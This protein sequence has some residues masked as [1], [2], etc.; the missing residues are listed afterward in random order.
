MRQS[1][2]PQWLIPKCWFF[3]KAS[4]WLAA[5]EYPCIAEIVLFPVYLTWVD[6]QNTNSRV[7]NTIGLETDQKLQTQQ[8]TDPASSRFSIAHTPLH[9]V[10]TPYHFQN[11]SI[12]LKMLL[13]FLW[14]N[15]KYHTSFLSHSY[16]HHSIL[17]HVRFSKKA[18]ARLLTNHA[19]HLQTPPMIA[20]PGISSIQHPWK[21]ITGT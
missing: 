9:T 1:P 10:V 7:K 6:H 5:F 11:F 16:Y 3:K 21:Q 19:T 4:I 12:C 17:S 13:H 2:K 20:L 8:S 15:S 18:L 14:R